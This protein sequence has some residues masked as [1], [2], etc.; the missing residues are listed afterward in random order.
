MKKIMKNNH[1]LSICILV[2]LVLLFSFLALPLCSASLIGEQYKPI[3]LYQTCNNCTY[4]NVTAI[5]FPD[6]H[7]LVIEK[8]MV[9]SESYFNYSLDSGNTTQL[10]EYQYCYECGNNVDVA[11]G[12]IPF[13]ISS[14]GTNLE[15]SQAIIYFIFLLAAVGT[16]AFCFYYAVKI[17][18]KHTAD[19][20][21]FIIGVNDLRY[22][23]IFLSVICYVLL[24][25][26]S[27]MLMSITQNFIPEL[28]VSGFFSWVY[29]VLL[30]L[31]YPVM[32]VAIIMMVFVFLTNKDLQRK[33]DLGIPVEMK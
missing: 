2:G 28:G 11:T 20:E 29:W 33:M 14:T 25:F 21:G 19:E 16:F 32:I 18:W 5:K 23:K 24:F 26:I 22:L 4:C 31:M 9:Q 7:D 27:A 10:G 13:I 12:C 3:E 1:V 6:H 15:T 17:E 30:A 8:V